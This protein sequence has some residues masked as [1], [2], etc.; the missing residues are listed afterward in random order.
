MAFQFCCTQGHLL[1]GDPSQIG[2]MC[3]CPYCGTPFVVPQDAGQPSGGFPLSPAGFPQMPQQGVL[4]GMGG[5]GFAPG[6]PAPMGQFYPQTMPLPATPGGPAAFAYPGVQSMPFG[7]PPMGS[8]QAGFFPAPMSYGPSPMGGGGLEMPPGQ[9]LPAEPA[10]AVDPAGGQAAGPPADEAENLPWG[11]DPRAK[12]PLPFDLPDAPRLEPAPAA[13]MPEGLS[14][15]GFPGAG[16][17]LAEPANDQQAAAVSLPEEPEEAKVFH[18]PCPSGH[19]L[20][21]TPEMLGKQAICPICRKQFQLRRE[22]SIEYR[23]GKAVARAIQEKARN[24]R[25]KRA[26]ELW[27]AWSILAAVAVLIGLIVLAFTMGR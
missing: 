22:N 19:A 12:A 21:V 14:L 11:F 15:P 16:G 7:T 26:G 24:L 13:T 20:E 2:Q 4:P 9:A 3:Q 6:T 10:G 23:Q 25:E 1:Q 18:I 8:P 17:F 5:A 27:L